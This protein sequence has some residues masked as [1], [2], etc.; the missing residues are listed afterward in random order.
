MKCR[1]RR[2]NK[3]NGSS[4]TVFLL[5]LL[6][7]LYSFSVINKVDDNS[8]S[9]LIVTDCLTGDTSFKWITSFSFSAFVHQASKSSSQFYS[10]DGNK[11][12]KCIALIRRFPCGLDVF[13]FYQEPGWTEW[14]NME[15]SSY[16]SH[17]WGRKTS[18]TL[19]EYSRSTSQGFGTSVIL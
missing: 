10:T 9:W 2:S 15:Q 19:Q 18:L 8:Q 6:V 11:L 7:F 13:L 5:L 4:L 17:D 14:Q 1:E 12:C 16:F 3:E